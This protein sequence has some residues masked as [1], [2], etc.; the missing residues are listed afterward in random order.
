MTSSRVV[1][2]GAFIFVG[3]LLFTVALFMIGNRRNLFADRFPVYTEF[4]RL[5]Q[6]EVGAVVRVAG[7]EAGEVTGIEVPRGPSG[8]FRVRMDVREDLR[9]LIRTD[10]VASTQT[11]GL[12]GAIFVEIRTGTEDAPAIADGGTIAGREPFSMADLLQQMSDTVNTVNT[13]VATLSDEMQTTVQQIALTATDA[14][15][16]MQEI[17]PEFEAMAQNGARISADAQLVIAG[18]RE[19][20]GSIGKLVNDDAL[21]NQLKSITQEAQGVVT[22]VRDVTAEA[23]RALADVRSK[24]GPAQGLLSDMRTTAVQAREAMADLADNLEAMKHNFLLRGF[25]NRRGFFDLDAISPADYRLGVLE[26]GDRKAVRIWLRADLLFAAGNDGVEVMTPQGQGRV[27]S[28][29]ATYLKYLPSNPLVVEGYATPGTTDEQ[30]RTAARRAAM[31][32]E[33][34]LRQYSLAPQYT[35]AIALGDEAQGSPAG[36]AWDGI[37]LTLF[38]DREALQFETVPARAPAVAQP[39]AA[40]ASQSR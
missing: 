9:P 39:A 10:S 40:P 4:A 24:D 28:A 38:L 27:N 16:L 8:K 19:G 20:R 13:T 35:G 1:G 34:V 29:M 15:G 37:A 18:I 32:R 26:N 6:L 2:A 11:E 14:R 12:V 21:Y 3:V 7:A 33:Y 22:N 25:F 23:R 36:G 17:K 5:G 30:F 31:V